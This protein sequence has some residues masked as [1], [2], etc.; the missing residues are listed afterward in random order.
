MKGVNFFQQIPYEDYRIEYRFTW[1]GEKYRYVHGKDENPFIDISKLI[2]KRPFS[3]KIRD[4]YFTEGESLYKD[5]VLAKIKKYAGPKCNFYDIEFKPYWLFP[6]EDFISGQKLNLV[7]NTLQT[8]TIDMSD[9][10]SY[11]NLI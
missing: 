4:A 8:R 1:G 5:N 9:Y 2:N 10:E 7:Y 6:S 11:V 3:K